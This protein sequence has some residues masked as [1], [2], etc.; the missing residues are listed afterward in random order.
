MT[1][2]PLSEQNPVWSSLPVPAVLK[3]AAGRALGR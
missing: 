3:N 1:S 2:S